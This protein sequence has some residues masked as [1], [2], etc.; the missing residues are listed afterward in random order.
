MRGIPPGDVTI[1]NS[2]ALITC[3]GIIVRFHLALPDKL[4]I[5]LFQIPRKVYPMFSLQ[6]AGSA[7]VIGQVS[8]GFGVFE[9]ENDR[10][11]V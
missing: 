4:P 5:E 7:A 11:L 3:K 1:F 10:I 2:F 9:P 8:A 6:V